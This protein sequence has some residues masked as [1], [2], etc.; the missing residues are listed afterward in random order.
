MSKWIGTCV[1]AVA[2]IMIT[3]CAAP[4]DGAPA[5][6]DHQQSQPDGSATSSAADA[7]GKQS[8][9]PANGSTS[10]GSGTNDSGAVPVGQGVYAYDDGLTVEVTALAPYTP[11][12]FAI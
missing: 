12:D 10:S 3:G 11:G 1:A 6:R 8:A 5:R 7:G 2:A 9:S 4:V